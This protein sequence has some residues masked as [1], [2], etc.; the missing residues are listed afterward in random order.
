MPTNGNGGKLAEAGKQVVKHGSLPISVAALI[1]LLGVVFKAGGDRQDF[2][3]R[4]VHVEGR[5]E[6]RTEELQ[7]ID[8]Q[9][10]QIAGDVAWIKGYLLSQQHGAKPTPP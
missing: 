7:N 1:G 5:I 2:I 4:L 10:N 3:Q 6:R 9:V 8:I